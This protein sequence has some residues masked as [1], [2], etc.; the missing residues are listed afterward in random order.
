MVATGSGKIDRVE[1]LI[2]LTLLLSNTRHPLTLQNIADQVPGYPTGIEARRQ[3]FE[4]DRDLLNAEGIPVSTEP[5]TEDP[6]RLGYRIKQENYFIEDPGLTPNEQVVL[7]MVLA[8]VKSQPDNSILRYSSPSFAHLVVSL[9]A[10]AGLNALY[11]GIV[12]KRPTIFS[13][14]GK[15]RRVMPGTLNF[16]KGH[17][18]LVAW[19]MD[20]HS[21]RTFRLDR[22]EGEITFGTRLDE[23]HEDQ[24]GMQAGMQVGDGADFV[25]MMGE[26]EPVKVKVLVDYP[27]ASEVELDL[28]MEKVIERLQGGTV[29]SLDVVNI[30]ALYSWVLSM[31][32]HAEIIDP[33]EVTDGLVARLR[34]MSGQAAG[35][36]P[37]PQ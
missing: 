5:L 9:P 35:K 21:R 1:R 17:W 24:A 22:I 4:R 23:E 32:V 12:T 6:S 14:Q 33:P 37:V 34:S 16:V 11:K 13:Y 3:A 2:D 36:R 25:W 10:G 29:F 30:E 18:Y 7:S 28:G 31:G 27:M 19:D 15:A 20:K 26:G 8:A